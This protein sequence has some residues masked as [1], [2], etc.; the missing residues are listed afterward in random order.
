[1]VEATAGNTGLGLALVAG[2]GLFVAVGVIAY[3]FLALN[4]R[5]ARS[6]PSRVPVLW[7][8]SPELPPVDIASSLM[9][10]AVPLTFVL[11]FLFAIGAHGA[12]PF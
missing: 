10:V 2:L 11:T 12:H 6:G 9:K 8:V 7:R 5:L 3:V 1:M 4:V